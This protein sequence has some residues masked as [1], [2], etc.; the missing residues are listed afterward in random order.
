MKHPRQSPSGQYICSHSAECMLISVLNAC[1]YTYCSMTSKLCHHKQCP[2]GI[3]L[4]SC[5]N[6]YSVLWKIKIDI[7][8]YTTNSEQVMRRPTRRSW[9]KEST[10]DNEITRF[11][12]LQNVHIQSCM[13]VYM[14]WNCPYYIYIMC[15]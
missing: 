15:I 2:M 11:N 3:T 4:C 7:N 5:M 12:T 1:L 6:S 14:L 9:N 8:L 10:N 13:H